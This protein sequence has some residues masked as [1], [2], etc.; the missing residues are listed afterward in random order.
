[1]AARARLAL[2]A[3][4]GT[5]VVSVEVPARADEAAYDH[6]ALP[7]TGI[8]DI[9]VDEAHGLAYLSGSATDDRI[10]VARGDGSVAGEITGVTGATDLALNADGSLL[11]AAVPTAE[12]SPRS[13]RQPPRCDSSPPATAPARARWHRLPTRSGTP[14]TPGATAAPRCSGSWT[15]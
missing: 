6:V 8:T 11:Y 12:R 13:T 4:V 15:R 5:L 2:L 14:R 3:L 7:L 9:A 10:V 1:M